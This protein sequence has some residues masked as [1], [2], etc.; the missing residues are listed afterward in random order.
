MIHETQF[1]NNS[2]LSD[3]EGFSPTQVKCSP[4]PYAAAIKKRKATKKF[5]SDFVITPQNIVKKK[6][7]KKVSQKQILP[8]KKELLT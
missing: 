3:S 7:V 2:S 4:A 8:V 5:K 1:E 6:P